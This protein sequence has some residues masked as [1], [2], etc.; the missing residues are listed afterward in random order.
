MK[1]EIELLAEKYDCL[2]LSS[3][4][5]TKFCD[6]KNNFCTFFC[7]CDRKTAKNDCCVPP[8]T[9]SFYSSTER[10]SLR[11]TTQT[12]ILLIGIVD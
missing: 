6:A 3:V 2:L 8:I 1:R 11:T 7:Y 10:N 4:G 5:S 12:I 9:F